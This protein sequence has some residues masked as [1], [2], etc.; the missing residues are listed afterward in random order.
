MDR[1]Q[2]DA[3]RTSFFAAFMKLIAIAPSSKPEGLTALQH[4]GWLLMDATY[5]PIDK[6]CRSR[7]R[8]RDAVLVR[9]LR[10][11]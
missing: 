7:D 5:E 10:R 11:C 1:H 8:K 9:A 6:K 3:C 4:K 2:T